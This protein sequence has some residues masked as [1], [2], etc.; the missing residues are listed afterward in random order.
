MHC[1]LSFSVQRVSCA[2][3]RCPLRLSGTFNFIFIYG[4]LSTLA[5][6][7]HVHVGARGGQKRALDSPE[8]ELQAVVRGPV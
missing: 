5:H 8:V 2:L 6:E 4:Y 7:H 1:G 3:A